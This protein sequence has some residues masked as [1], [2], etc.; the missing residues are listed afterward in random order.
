VV[1]RLSVVGNGTNPDGVK[2]HTGDVVK[3]IFDTRE[4]STA[5]VVKILAR[6]EVAIGFVE[7]IGQQLVD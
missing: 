5:V 1:V 2:T 7:T 6:T 4:S 3:L